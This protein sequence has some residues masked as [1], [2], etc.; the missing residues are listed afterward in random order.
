MAR[1]SEYL[2]RSQASEFESSAYLADAAARHET[3]LGETPNEILVNEMVRSLQ[4]TAKGAAS[5]SNASS[6]SAGAGAQ[7]ERSLEELLAVV[8]ARARR[9][10]HERGLSQREVAE[11]AGLDRAY[12]SSI[13]HGKQNITLGALLRL[14]RALGTGVHQLLAG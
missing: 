4:R 1:N 9:A 5:L 3:D 10:R 2:E 12:L 14:A 8:G 13:E 7:D 11:A 6:P